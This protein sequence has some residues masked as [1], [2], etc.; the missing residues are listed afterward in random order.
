[1]Q[2]FSRG[3]TADEDV[4]HRL[5]LDPDENSLMEEIA[6]VKQ[7]MDDAYNHFQNASDPDL[8]DCCIYKG[9]A[10]WK[11]YQFLLRQAKTTQ[12]GT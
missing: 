5:A 9:N 10:A 7:E 11:R 4:Y 3:R 2:L 12:M 8:I 1:M 6:Q